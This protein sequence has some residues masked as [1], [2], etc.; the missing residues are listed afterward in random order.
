[1]TIT[2]GCKER[3][4]SDTKIIKA[5]TVVSAN[6]PEILKLTTSKA[7]ETQLNSDFTVKNFT[8]RADSIRVSK[9]K[10]FYGDRTFEPIWATPKMRA[11]FIEL[12]SEID[13]EGLDPED[14]KASKLANLNQNSHNLDNSKRT[15]L[16]L[17]LTDSFFRVCKDL[18]FG[19]LDPQELNAIWGI[20]R[21][22]L[23]IGELLLKA[24][25]SRNIKE[26]LNS[27]KQNHIVYKG[28]KKSLKEFRSKKEIEVKTTLIKEGEL[29]KLED[30]DPRIPS[31]VTRLAELN[32]AIPQRIKDSISDVYTESLQEVIMDFQADNGLETDGVIGNGTISN[33]NKNAGDKYN[34]ILANLER[35]RWYPRDLGDQYIIVNIANY[36][37]ALVKNK[38]TLSQHKTMVGIK[39]R[40]TPI[41]TDKVE[42]VVYNPTW[43]V[44]PTI[45]KKDVIPGA[46]KSLSYLS[47][48]NMKI[49][50]RNGEIIDPASINW[51]SQETKNYI[52]RQ[53]SGSGNPLGKVKII[54]P[55]KYLIYLHDTPSKSLFKNNV[56]SQSSGCVRVENAIELSKY[57]LSDQEK[58][59]EATI[60]SIMASGTTTQIKVNREVYVHHFYWTAWR[61]NNETKFI[62]DIYDLDKDIYL[63]LSEK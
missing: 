49:F 40:K 27:I 1:M 14:Y 33:L 63:K 48:R 44:P 6:Q 24:S 53:S 8:F 22:T 28:L 51:D 23:A 60:D 12:V 50:N 25:K 19:K 7:L 46:S 58:Y 2:F 41:F 61:E 29:I 38:D 47:D 57:L 54:Y 55:N 32:Y 52:F 36:N 62:N 11:D 20:E 30:R 42:Y 45:K 35:W 21:D 16:E 34:Q 26:A 3:K 37:L 10:N 17:Q 39:S 15:A 13:E 5:E 4:D 43:T 18:Y 59:T 56:R 31:I 9:I